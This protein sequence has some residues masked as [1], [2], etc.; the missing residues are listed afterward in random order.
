[1]QLEPELSGNAGD[2]PSPEFK[3]T[4]FL[5]SKP[6]SKMKACHNCGIALYEDDKFYTIGGRLTCEY[7]SKKVKGKA[8]KGG[9]AAAP[10]ANRAGTSSSAPLAN[11]IVAAI[12][13]AVV[14][15]IVATAARLEVGFMAF[16]VG[17]LVGYA[18]KSGAQGKTTRS[19][20]FT[21]VVLVYMSLVVAH[22]AIGV[23]AIYLFGDAQVQAGVQQGVQQ[24][25][26]AGAGGATLGVV[27]TL[28]LSSVVHPFVSGVLSLV[29]LAIGM[30]QAW[31]ASAP[32]KA[33]TKDPVG[34]RPAVSR[35]MATE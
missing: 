15:A 31:R 24:M 35:R 18:V 19:M 33:E 21:A 12:V 17:W 26:D 6:A 27:L 20:R 10:V 25:K 7:C 16:G 14:Y 9:V 30:F 4:T 29:F 8:S 22:T 13:A 2:S 23:A 11:G 5:D 32:S 34:V 3:T 1:M 28:L